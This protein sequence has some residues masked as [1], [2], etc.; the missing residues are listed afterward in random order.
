[1][2][3]GGKAVSWEVD[4]VEFR[5]HQSVHAVSHT[6]PDPGQSGAV[7]KLSDT[8]AIVLSFRSGNFQSQYCTSTEIALRGAESA[9][10]WHVPLNFCSDAVV[11]GR[12]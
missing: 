11:L 1:M 10:L 8:V 12:S 2:T 4:F 3:H 7:W 5:D 6:P 9:V